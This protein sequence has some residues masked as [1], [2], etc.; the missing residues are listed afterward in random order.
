L[1]PTPPDPAS[2]PDTGPGGR[3]G[4]TSVP[5]PKP[6]E[7][8]GKPAVDA[9]GGE[10]GCRSTDLFCDDFE[11]YDVGASTSP[12]WTSAIAN[13]SL[14]V[15]NSRARSGKSLK[16]R[17]MGNGRAQIQISGLKPPN[18]SFFG[19]IH[20]FFSAFPS[21]PNYAHYTVVEASGAGSNTLVR[22]IG[23]QLIDDRGGKKM[24]G[25]GS[26]QGPT[27]DWTRWK[28]TA[29]S[30]PQKWL[31]LE[32]EMNATDNAVR[33]WIDNVAKPELTVSTKDHGGAAN[34]DFVFPMVN[35]VYV[36]WWLYQGNPTPAQFDVWVDDIAFRTTRVG[37]P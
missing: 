34:Q 5:G 31:C 30:E 11:A 24:W 7:D 33:I 21:A 28:E 27:G 12:K 10:S 36:G 20:A 8:A 3:D 19:R 13:G 26:D 9:N 14:M 32:W 18:N 35:T 16:L 25:V 22:P 23:G 4:G 29:I 17:T 6:E 1:P 37:C 2:T 15:D